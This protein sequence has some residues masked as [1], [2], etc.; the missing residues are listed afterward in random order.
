MNENKLR[1]GKFGFLNNFLPYFYLEKDG[2]YGVI[3]A[4]PKKMASMLFEGSIVYA[5]VPV[6]FYLKNR[7]LLRNYNFC[8]ASKEKVLSV[9]VVSRDKRMDDGCIALTNQSM[10]S[11][12]LLKIIMKEKG[13]NNRL[14]QVNAAS[15][16]E[17]LEKCNHALVI[18]DEAIKARMAFR[19]QMDLGEEWYD[20]TGLPMVFGISASLRDYDASD[21]DSDVMKSVDMGFK[22]FGRVVDEAEEQFKMPKEF[23]EEY[24]KTL[25]Y[26]L[27]TKE[28]KSLE[29][30]EEMCHEYR[31]L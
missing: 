19:V 29:T 27:G 4:S 16:W 23:L 10:T 6:F 15:A 30:F 21:I 20:L 11:I 31:L 5:P 9:V 8:V 13:I 2:R 14:M 28:K 3:E 22:N 1:I 18:G 24:F 7:S 25:T 26:S 12:N 17:L